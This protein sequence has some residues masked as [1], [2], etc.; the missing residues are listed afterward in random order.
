MT[1]LASVGISFTTNE[2][3]SYNYALHYFD[4]AADEGV[5]DIPDGRS[6]AND[7]FQEGPDM[8]VNKKQ[9][10]KNFLKKKIKEKIQ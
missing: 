1:G 8:D 7:P 9:K 3:G 10:W 6:K 5:Q 2:K 4:S